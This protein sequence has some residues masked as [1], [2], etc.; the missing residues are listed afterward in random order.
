VPTLKEQGVPDVEVETWY[1]AL[2][3]AERRPPS[4]RG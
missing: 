2:A 4:L 1:G 3:P